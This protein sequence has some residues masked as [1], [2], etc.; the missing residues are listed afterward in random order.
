MSCVL[1]C[2]ALQPKRVR[3]VWSGVAVAAPGP[4]LGR[5][6]EGAIIAPAPVDYV[7]WTE[8]VATFAKSPDLAAPRRTIWLSG[9][10]SPR[11]KQEFEV[12]G[13]T[14]QEGTAS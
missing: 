11:A 12:L 5:D 1:S 6:R 2:H 14:V 7:S 3:T 10:M 9:K 8:R 4:V 13:W